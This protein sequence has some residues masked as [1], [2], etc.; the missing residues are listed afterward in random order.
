MADR[1]FV[2]K[3][4]DGENAVL[5]DDEAHHIRTVMRAKPGDTIVVFD[6]TGR[7]FDAQIEQVDRRRVELQITDT[8]TVDRESRV[9]VTIAAALPKGNRQ[10]WLVEKLVELGCARLIPLRTK[11][12]IVK[13]DKSGEKLERM[14][15]EATKQ[16][17]RN[18]LMEIAAPLDFQ[19]LIARD[20]LPDRRLIAHPPE[21]AGDRA[22]K[23]DWSESADPVIAAIGPEGGFAEEEVDAALAAEWVCASLGRRVLRLETAAE[24]LAARLTVD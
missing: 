20:D 1:Y 19:D 2:E 18:R 22:A 3:P 9:E 14:V 16:C 17:G 12:S 8:R 13:P 11:R 7:E 24:Y 15:L 23:I 5:I 4:I 10:R 6:G 21:L